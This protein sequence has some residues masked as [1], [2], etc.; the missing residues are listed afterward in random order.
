MGSISCTFGMFCWSELSSDNGT[1]ARKFYSHV[2]GWLPSDDG[3]D[4][5][6]SF[7]TWA[8]AGRKVAG[9]VEKSDDQ[10]GPPVWNSFVLVDDLDESTK[11]ADANGGQVTLE[12]AD[13]VPFGKMGIIQDPTGAFLTLWE[14]GSQEDAELFSSPGS[15]AWNELWTADSS[16]ARQFYSQVWV[17]R[18]RRSMQATGPIT[19]AW[20]VTVPTA[21][22]G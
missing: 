13:V 16:L 10:P 8:V 22:F 7:T 4:L 9:M 17:G 11:L 6:N 12:C 18:T 2:F 19:F 1:E 14:A 15:I 3:G 21:E 5:E 20:L